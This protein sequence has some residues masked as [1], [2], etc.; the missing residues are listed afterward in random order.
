[1]SA[2]IDAPSADSRLRL[3]QAATEAFMEEGYR[4]S[5][6]RIAARAGVAKQTLYNHFS[7]KDDLFAE[8][9][10]TAVRSVLVTLEEEDG[11]LRTH[12]LR[13]CAA[14]RERVLC[15]VGLAMFR[16]VVAEAPRFPELSRSFFAAGPAVTI[17]R[18]AAFI[19]QAMEAKQLRRDDPRLAAEMLTGTLTNY[20][21]LRGLIGG[22]SELLSDTAKPERVVE[23]FLRAYAPT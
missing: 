17:D 7:S 2:P 18:L 8:V 1:M 13:F 6:D 22:E 21:R 10:R 4:V 5:V 14:Y 23:C 9:V 12:L 20:D 3:L 15:P 19:A 11:D 16:T